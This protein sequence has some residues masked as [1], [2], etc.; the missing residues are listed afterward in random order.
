MIT[1]TVIL[2]LVF[3]PASRCILSS[4]LWGIFAVLGVAF[5][6]TKDSGGRRRGF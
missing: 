4:V 6:I 1:L 2:V 5:L 3:V